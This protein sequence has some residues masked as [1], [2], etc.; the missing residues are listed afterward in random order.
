MLDVSSVMPL[1]LL[2]SWAALDG[3]SIGQI[4]L[5]RPI[6]SATLAGWLVGDPATGLLLGMIF[7]GSHLGELPIGGARLPE[8]GPAAV[9][10][11]AAAVQIG[12]PGGLAIGLAIGV[13]WSVVGGLSVTAQRHL[14]GVLTRP[15]GARWSSPGQLSRRHWACIL[16]DGLRGAALTAA[17]VGLAL[18]L[19]QSLGARWS[20]PLPHTVALFLMPSFLA[21][22]ALLRTW[23]SSRRRR[24]ILTLGCAAGAVLAFLG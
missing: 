17:G 1:A 22:G 12:G 4:M 19:P 3:T 24:L 2:G 14:N 7:E 18:A 6:V 8:A 10:A 9:P 13:I 11:V 16:A 21:G 20:L 15:P 23:G 5:S